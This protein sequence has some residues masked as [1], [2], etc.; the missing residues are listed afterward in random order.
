MED[1]KVMRFKISMHSN[2]F[3]L[4]FDQIRG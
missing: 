4:C 3:R 1:E 2:L